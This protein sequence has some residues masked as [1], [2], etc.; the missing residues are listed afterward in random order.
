MSS[1]IFSILT[2]LIILYLIHNELKLRRKLTDATLLLE[3][4][5][6][7]FKILQKI[8]VNDPLKDINFN[9]LTI[10]H[11]I[12]KLFA[13][14]DVL[15]TSLNEPMYTIFNELDGLPIDK[16][17][18]NEK[19][20]KTFIENISNRNFNA[21]I[22]KLKNKIEKTNDAKIKEM[23]ELK[24]QKLQEARTLYSTIDENSSDEYSLIVKSNVAILMNEISEIS[25]NILNEDEL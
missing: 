17:P 5:N 10:Q 13:F 22:A 19:E 16:V 1:I 12:N 3:K 18:K 20:M 23:I 21:L 6:D 9:F 25:N 24:L 11:E 2:F 7:T 4:A 14:C 15:K 8:T